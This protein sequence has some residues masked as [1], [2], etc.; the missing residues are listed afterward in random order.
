MEDLAF[1]TL[2]VGVF[3]VFA[4]SLLSARG[5]MK[6]PFL[7][8][9]VF[10]GWVLPQLWQV[11]RLYVDVAPEYLAG[12][13]YFC[14]ACLLATVFGWQAGVRWGRKT[15]IY[16]ALRIEDLVLI[17]AIVTA[18]AWMMVLGMGARS[19][20]EVN[21]S[22]W[23]GPLTIMYFFSNLKVI[24]LFLSIFLF[25]KRRSPLVIAL[26]VANLFLYAPAV[27]LLFR[28]RAM[29][30][31]LTATMLAFWFARRIALP[32][33]MVLAAVPIGML[34]V[35]SVG[36]LR[37]LGRDNTS[38][39]RWATVSQIR[40]VDFWS[41]TPFANAGQAPEMVNALNL[42]R[43]SGDQGINTYGRVSWNRVIFQWV[44]AQIVGADV[45][46]GLMFDSIDGHRINQEFNEE[47]RIGSTPTA[48]GEAYLEFGIFGIVFFFAT[49]L[50]TARWWAQAIRGSFTAMTLY[51]AALASAVLMPT[52]YAIYFF[53]TAALYVGAFL[54]IRRF[55]ISR[56]LGEPPVGA[57]DG[58]R[59]WQSRRRDTPSIGIDRDS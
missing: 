40:S 31:A 32:R 46:Q 45:K 17:C 18:I 35:F 44:P 25:L 8:S 4:F 39:A 26:F 10:A 33:L 22:T 36:S 24:S 54:F 51:A 59:R 20:D 47:D 23:S 14:L 53:N 3:A 13:Y 42:V 2:T 7:V 16:D 57:L 48:M 27:L 41:S 43:F 1:S 21:S 12:L 28:R 52:A 30:E 37:G 50:F 15:P 38:E 11:R 49:A 5:Y 29:L 6:L 9:A 19:F 58:L 55:V 56:S 34:V